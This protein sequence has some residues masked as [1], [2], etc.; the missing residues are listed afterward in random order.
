MRRFLQ[1]VLPSRF[2]RIRHGG[3]YS[4]AA[5]EAYSRIAALLGHTP[6]PPEEPWQ[7]KCEDCGGVLQVEAITVGRITIIPAAA[8]LRRLAALVA[9]N[10]PAAATTL[11]RAP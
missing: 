7:A 6:T 4:C 1:H 3:F 10:Q 5:G 2:Q 9:R 8:R 11:E